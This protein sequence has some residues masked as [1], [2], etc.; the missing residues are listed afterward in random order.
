MSCDND[1]SKCLDTYSSNCIIWEGPDIPCLG[2]TSKQ[3][4]TAVETAIANEVC[5][6]LGDIDVSTVTL[7]AELIGL[8]GSNNQSISNLFQILI[9]YGVTL[10]DII[11]DIK[12]EFEAS[13]SLTLDFKC[14]TPPATINIQSS[15]QSLITSYCTLKQTVDNLPGAVT[16]GITNTVTQVLGNV[17]TAIQPNRVVKTG[18]GSS[19]KVA[20]R[21]FVPYYTALAYYGT[22]TD[23][24]STGKG[25]TNSPMDG[26][27]ICNGNNGT[28]DLRGRSLVG[29]TL[30]VG[31]GVLHPDVNPTQN[32]GLGAYQR[33]GTGGAIR[34]K[35][36]ES[37]MPSHIHD[38]YD[39]GHQH[40][41]QDTY[42]DP[43]AGGG[44]SGGWASGHTKK[45]RY[46][47][48]TTSVGYANIKQN[49]KGGNDFH[50]NRMPYNVTVWIMMKD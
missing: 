13:K 8:L 41:V 18:Q 24:D 36:N 10:R 5:I 31:G 42:A 14:I 3:S 21:G 26:W 40:T 32:G 30:E 50:E 37:Q 22:L 47:L 12:T 25:I 23:F 29:A 19:F 38:V 11:D 9:D 7:T 45:Y 43:I 15:I 33:W 28:P 17:L 44:I 16:A 20:F 49:S 34:V 46:E 27:Y 39:A 2:I 1:F 48:P 35:L 6:I 4:L